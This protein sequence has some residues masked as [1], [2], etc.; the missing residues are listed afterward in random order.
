MI[1]A[2]QPSTT[3]RRPAR[4]AA[5]LALFWLGLPGP[6]ARP[7]LP[8]S[9][10]IAAHV[11][12]R[13]SEAAVVRAIESIGMTVADMDRS[14]EFFT[15]VLDFEKVSD[16]EV[17]GPDYGRLEGV[18]GA[19][20]RVVRLRLG[21]EFVD[22]TDYLTPEGRP[23]PV[24]SRSND[25]WFQHIAIIVRDMDAAYRRLRD[26]RVAHTSTSPQTL[27]E[28]NRA[29]AGI[30]AFYFKDPDGHALEILQF[31]AGKGDPRWQRPAGRLFVGIDHTAIVVRDTEASLRL[32]R[33]ALGLRVAGESENYGVEQ[34]H[35]NNV[36]GARLRITA[37]RAAE[38]PGIE[39]LEYLS[40]SD[41]RPSPDDVRSNDLIHWQTRLKVD[42]P[43]AALPAV[44]PAGA[45]LVSSGAITL[46]DGALGFGVA[47]LVRDPDGHALLLTSDRRKP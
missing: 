9:A 7:A 13:A 24:D 44:R 35:L 23:V 22:L 11:T 8:A 2:G 1:P 29:A 30:R 3:P 33:D 39:F 18:F 17:A 21:D 37:L 43:A 42:D 19:R 20:Q 46:S 47:M 16:V 38:G 6:G 26:H 34:E 32:Y 36:F 27:P 40:P 4:A 45:R 5:I 41:G 12:A 10:P 28:W 14:V 15:G 25:R 31:P